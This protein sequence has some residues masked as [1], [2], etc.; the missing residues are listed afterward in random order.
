M[1]VDDITEGAGQIDEGIFSWFRRKK[2]KDQLPMNM[3][4]LVEVLSQNTKKFKRVKLTPEGIIRLT[5]SNENPQHITECIQE[6]NTFKT[7]VNIEKRNFTEAM[8]LIRQ[9]NRIDSANDLPMTG[10]GR[11]QWARFYRILTMW[12]RSG[13]RQKVQQQLKKFEDM[14]MSCDAILRS[15]DEVIVSL[16]QLKAQL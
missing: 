12:S 2:K 16:K 11:S 3:K 9:Q 6:L 10:L 5:K 14:V 15:I 1:R 13:R 7:M 8:K 4:D